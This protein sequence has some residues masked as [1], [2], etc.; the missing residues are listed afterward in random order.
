M[1]NTVTCGEYLVK[2]LEAFGIETIF[3]I[4]GVHTIEFYRGLGH[5]NI[6]HITPRHE[7]GAG[8]MADGYFRASGKVA[9]CFI[10]TGP[11]M[12]NITTA[13]GQAYADSIPMLVISS[14]NQRST[15]G[16]GQGRLH[17]LP[18]QR[19]LINGVSKFSYT[20]MSPNELP[21]ILRQAFA[22][23]NS[24]RPRPV[25][26]EIPLDVI[27]MPADHLSVHGLPIYTKP[28]ASF[29][30]ITQSVQMLKDAKNGLL[31]LGGGA[32]N[33][34]QKSLVKLAETFD[35]PVLYT[36][37]AKGVF[38]KNHKLALGSN[39]SV[40]A[41]RHLVANADVIL[42]VGTELGETDY[43]TV[44]NGG[45]EINGDIIRVDIDDHQLQCNYPAKLGIVSDAGAYVDAVCQYIDE[46]Q[47]LPRYHSESH[48]VLAV[49]QV[50]NEILLDGYPK[51]WLVQ[52]LVLDTLH[53]N[54]PDAVF[55][56]DS[57]QI[58]YSGNHLFESNRT[59]QWFN[60]STGY[61]TLGYA[62]PA[63]VGAL[64]S[65]QKNVFALVGDGG[66]QFTLNELA[67]AVE[68]Q[69]P[70]VIILWNNQGYQEIKRY[71]INND[72][73]AVGVDIYTPDFI[74]ISEGYGCHAEQLTS[75]DDLSEQVTQAFTRDKPTVLM[76][77]EVKIYNQHFN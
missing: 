51:E 55:V 14:V 36:I 61:G 16:L 10:I 74:K 3:G 45:F 53:K 30:A 72:I 63:A 18:D 57:T 35:L 29:E 69:L 59:R 56:G 37:N 40:G 49:Q 75:M 21:E 71:M 47:L 19:A 67:T 2:Q 76:I 6:K 32:I 15:L 58:V 62:L 20:L 26:I 17:E 46:H 38:P 4:P 66:F 50:R 64:L 31:L 24:D 73:P 43:D 25:H 13:M 44:F 7:Q 41:V 8:F 52:K 70:L 42:A 23:F 48:A 34:S 33:A 68:E 60:A 54:Y 1:T 12:T 39:Q 11:G 9:A 22:V 77:D 5:T 28:I 65:G 27:V